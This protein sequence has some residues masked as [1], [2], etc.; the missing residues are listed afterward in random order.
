MD[1]QDKLKEESETSVM[2]RRTPERKSQKV[3]S[4]NSSR[5]DSD[6]RSHRPRVSAGFAFC[7]TRL[8]KKV[9]SQREGAKRLVALTFQEAR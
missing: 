3:P 5:E 9:E 1:S 2:S 4:K 7:E 8:Y 6:E